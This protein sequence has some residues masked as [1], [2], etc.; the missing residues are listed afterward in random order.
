MKER[1]GWFRVL[2][3]GAYR[4]VLQRLMGRL[5]FYVILYRLMKNGGAFLCKGLWGRFEACLCV[6]IVLYSYKEFLHVTV[7]HLV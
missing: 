5:Y 1:Y 7:F 3:P 4:P 6:L 2:P